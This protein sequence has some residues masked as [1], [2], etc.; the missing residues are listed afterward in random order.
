VERAKAVVGPVPE[1]LDTEALVHLARAK[2]GRSPAARQDL[3]AALALLG[4]VEAQA[5][6]A[7]TYFH[8][9]QVWDALA[10]LHGAAREEEA[11]AQARDQA[12]KAWEEARRR[13]LSVADLHPLE[14]A[15]FAALQSKFRR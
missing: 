13:N 6:N 1:L 3:E 8:L 7:I 4:D 10:Q 11:A 5:P 2:A 15:D 9:A 12:G 14:R